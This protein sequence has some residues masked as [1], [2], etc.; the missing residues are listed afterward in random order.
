MKRI[1]KSVYLVTVLLVLIVAVGATEYRRQQ[2]VCTKVDVQVAHQGM[3]AFIDEREVREL[4]S[5]DTRPVIGVALA[6][7]DL[8][9]LERQVESNPYVDDANVHYDLEGRV[10]VQVQ[11]S[12]PI[13][14]LVHPKLPD[15]YISDKGKL[16]P[17]SDQHTARVMLISGDYI[18]K[19]NRGDWQQDSLS[20]PFLDLVQYIEQHAFWR[21]QIAQMDVNR[22]G[23]ITLH[24]QVGKQTI[25]FGKPIKISEK[26]SK[27]KLF[28]QQI[29]PRKGWNHYNW[30]NVTYENQI[31]CD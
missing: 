14:R 1:K 8:K 10:H 4:V 6:K 27:L 20:A 11:Q 31:V 7:L 18:P 24:P 12:R 26:F 22:A 2:R 3:D 15:A 9:Q 25:K 16:L 17:L 29:L 21:A 19:L 30:V 5:Q 13:A 23:E 28:Y